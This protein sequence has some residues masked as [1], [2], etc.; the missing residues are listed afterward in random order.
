MGPRRAAAAAHG[1]S[2]LSRRI[3]VPRQRR[4]RRQQDACAA[5]K[6]PIGLR[7]SYGDS[8]LNGAGAL[9]DMCGL[10][11][12][13]SFDAKNGILRAEA[14][15]SFSD[16]LRFAVPKGWFAPTT[17][18]TRFVTLGG[19]LANDVHGKNHHD[20]GPIGRHVRSFGIDG[21]LFAAVLLDL[22]G[23]FLSLMEAVEPGALTRTVRS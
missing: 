13:I 18:G 10:D 22:V 1:S 3:A 21:S 14:G 19:A 2:T 4:V 15:V 16:I 9:I 8:C 6:L 23:D 20:A 5:R 11:R 7:R 12:F 17:P